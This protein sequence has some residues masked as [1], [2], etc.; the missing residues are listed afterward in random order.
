MGELLAEDCSCCSFGVEGVGL[1]VVGVRAS[2]CRTD[3]GDVEAGLAQS[4]GNS[5]PV[6][7]GAHDRCENAAAG[8]AN[9]PSDRACIAGLGRGK[10]CGVDDRTG[11]GGDQA[12][13]VGARMGVDADDVLELLGDDS[14]LG[15]LTRRNADVSGSS[16]WGRSETHL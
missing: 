11:R 10:A 7:R 15:L 1:A 16:P 2:G 5:G 12:V 8:P 9:D 13:G 6:G 14:Q 4:G 3:L